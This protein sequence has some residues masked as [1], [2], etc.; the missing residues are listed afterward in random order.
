MPIRIRPMVA[1]ILAVGVLDI[2]D[3][4]I[5][6]GLRGVPPIRILQ[7]VASGLLGREAYAGGVGTAALG[8]TLHFLIASGVV[9]TYL[10]ASRRLPALAA[11]PLVY[12]PL[13]GVA[14]YGVMYWMV[15]P[16]SAIGGGGPPVSVVMLNGI[17]IHI[18]G[19]G[20]PAALAAR[21]ASSP[22]RAAG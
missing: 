8:L 9:T 10:V 4:L 17:L 5:F 19:V 18:F 3:A 13:Y 11:R 21:A 20:I 2:L 15:I 16:L 14:V 6:F 1:G 22:A 12:G 7:G